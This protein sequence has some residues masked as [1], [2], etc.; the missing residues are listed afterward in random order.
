MKRLLH[1]LSLIK[2]SHTIFAM[3]FALVGFFVGL[4]FEQQNEITLNGWQKVKD[5]FIEQWMVFFHI[6]LC[7]I[8][9]RSAAMAFNRYLDR[10]FDA[11]NPRTAIREIP[12]GIISPT[13]A[14]RFTII[15]SLLFM[16]SAWMINP[17]CFWLSPVA[18]IV[19]LGY[20]YTKRFTPLCHLILGLG[21][22]LAPVGAFIA[23]TEQVNLPIILLSAAVIGWVSGFDIIYAL[24]D[25][26]FDTSEGLH[27]IPSY[28]GRKNALLLS[29]ILHF[30]TALLLIGFGY[31][32]GMHWIYYFGL[33]IYTALLFYQQSIVRENDLSKVDIAF[34]TSNGFASIIFAFFSITDLIYFG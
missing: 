3:P 25:D 8:F 9:A 4:L 29:R 17:T 34:M 27:S 1:Y 21:L 7:M 20:S 22:S 23:V 28:M 19:I 33:I 6:L 14:L 12:R 31:M 16:G 2:F 5:Y 10:T 11:K 26:A 24:Q 18:L 30:I 32:N 15:N 13:S